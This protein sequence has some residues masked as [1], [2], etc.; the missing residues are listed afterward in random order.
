MKMAKG[1]VSEMGFSIVELLITLAVIAIVIAIVL[2]L[3]TPT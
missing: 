2:W 1:Q 3:I